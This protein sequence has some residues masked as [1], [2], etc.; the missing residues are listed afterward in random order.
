MKQWSA[1]PPRTWFQILSMVLHLAA[2][3]VLHCAASRG[4]GLFKMLPMLTTIPRSSFLAWNP[5][6]D[7]KLCWQNL[8]LT[9]LRDFVIAPM[10]TRVIPISI[11][12]T[13]RS[14][15]HSLHI[16]IL[17]VSKRCSRMISVIL[18]IRQFSI[19][20]EHQYTPIR[21]TYFYA[22]SSPTAFVVIPPKEANLDMHYSNPPLLALRSGISHPY[23]W[24]F[25]AHKIS[26]QMGPV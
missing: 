19:W 17:A 20:T 11:S 9:L 26:F 22:E 2:R 25:E 13:Q 12:Q 15:I 6:D 10:Q 23:S 21:A 3:L 4:G 18:P 8:T 14:N 1:S 5:S 16:E 7:S 24:L